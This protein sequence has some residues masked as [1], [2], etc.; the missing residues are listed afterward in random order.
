MLSFKESSSKT[1]IDPTVT[2]SISETGTEAPAQGLARSYY[3]IKAHPGQV[4]QDP[5][6]WHPDVRPPSICLL[7]WHLTEGAWQ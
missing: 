7:H 6:V 4:P 1:G 5:T 2:R 3:S